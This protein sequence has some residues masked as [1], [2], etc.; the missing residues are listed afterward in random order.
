MNSASRLRRSSS[1]CLV[2]SAKLTVAIGATARLR[3]KGVANGGE[4]RYCGGGLVLAVVDPRQLYPHPHV[5]VEQFR[6]LGLGLGKGDRGWCLTSVETSQNTLH[7]GAHVPLHRCLPP[8]R[9]LGHGRDSLTFSKAS[10]GHGPQALVFGGCRVVNGTGSCSDKPHLFA[11]FPGRRE[12]CLGGRCCP[13]FAIRDRGTTRPAPCS[14]CA[15]VPALSS[16][17]LYPDGEGDLWF[18]GHAAMSPPA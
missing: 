1:E 2:A 8:R 11:L 6:E 18:R 7:H 14:V 9:L 5:Q 4:R 16:S 17:W 15:P 12:Q 3:L 10:P 13:G